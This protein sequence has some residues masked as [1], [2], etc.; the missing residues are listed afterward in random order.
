MLKD[1]LGDA[2]NATPLG[3]ARNATPLGD[4]RNATPLGVPADLQ[5]A[6]KKCSTY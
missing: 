3:D 5:S 6:V 1:P 4:A 2:R